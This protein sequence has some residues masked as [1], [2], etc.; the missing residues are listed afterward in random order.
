MKTG[1][2]IVKN[3]RIKKI[4]DKN[5]SSFYRRIFTSDE[6]EY[7][8][9]KNNDFKS[10]AGLFAAKEAISKI[11]GTGI[12]ELSWKDIEILHTDKGKPYIYLNKKLEKKLNEL[13]INA[14][15]LSISH[16]EEYT[17]AFAI[18]Y[19]SQ[20]TRKIAKSNGRRFK[21]NR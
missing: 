3:E 18:G 19:L 8:D 17:I 21:R 13:N 1:V 10:V 16:E 5:R 20:E 15:E 4:L 2:D 11:F 7:L 9:I 14:I 6:V 12:G